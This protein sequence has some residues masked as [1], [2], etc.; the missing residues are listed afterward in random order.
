MSWKKWS[1]KEWNEALVNAIFLAP[2][3]VDASVSRI[4]ASGRFL[5][6]C[7]RD[8]ES[9]TEEAQKLFINTFGNNA[10]SVRAKF[11]S[12]T[13]AD[14]HGIP[15]YFAVLYLT[16]LAS[17]A[18]NET[19][20]VGDFRDRFSRI[21]KVTYGHSVDFSNL[22]RMWINVEKWSKL[23]GQ[24]LGDCASLVLPNPKNETLIGYSKRIAFPAYRDEQFLR[25][26]LQKYSL[27]EASSFAD[28][29]TAVAREIHSNKTFPNFLE[30]FREF[31]KLTARFENQQAYD[32]PF[33]GAVRDICIEDTQELVKKKGIANLTIDITDGIPPIQ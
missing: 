26:T 21:V 18:D 1:L 29:A 20:G 11:R 28:V 12:V 4:D 9:S 27:S 15:S 19:A 6:K 17:S 24:L 13:V 31:Q 14:P 33:W 3:R 7:T 5:V 2:G 22:P 32:S 30:E 8:V 10:S 23:R 16:L 25:K